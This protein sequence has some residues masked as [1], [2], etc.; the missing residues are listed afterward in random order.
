MNEEEIKKE[1]L[2]LASNRRIFN[3]YLLFFAVVFLVV[4]SFWLGFSRGQQQGESVAQFFPIAG[5]TIENRT[6]PNRKEV[7]FGLF[8]KVW[9]LL[10][11]KYV[12]KAALD[13]Q[14]LVYG[15]IRGM[16]KATGDPYTTFFDP[17]E[18]KS[19]SEDL[20]GSFDGIGA[21]LGIKDDILTVIAPLEDSPAKKAGL[22]AGDKVLKIGD[23]VTSDMTID[24]A[25]TLIRGK[26]GTEVKLTV[27]SQGGVEPREVT[28]LRDTIQVKSVTVEFKEG[29]I[30]HLKINKFGETT[31]NEFDKIMNQMLANGTKGIVLDLRN[32]PGGFLDKSVDIASRLLPKGKVVVTEEDYTGKKENLYTT[33]GDKL[34]SLPIV[35]L[36]N[37][38]SA[39]ASEILAGALRDNRQIKLVGQKSFGKGS[40]QELLSLA[41]GAS[42]KV[43][44]AKWLTPSGEYIMEKGI[45]PDAEVELTLDDFNNNRDPQFDRALEMLKAEL[46]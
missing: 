25:V 24:E 15:A 37:E 11:E 5:T 13:A 36:I 30:A 17:K 32:N 39:S 26:K 29:N 33:G 9:D 28:I 3:R 42:I 12:D 31:D 41:G 35:V 40:V 43:T 14:Q 19:F 7:D 44:V 38:G 20:E 10:K 23:K 21:E 8:W 46:K 18:T 2:V 16:V 1:E 6:D 27:F 4:A 22:M 45:T 34:S